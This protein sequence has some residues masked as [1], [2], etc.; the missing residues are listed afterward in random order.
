MNSQEFSALVARNEIPSVLFFEGREEHLKQ[1]ALKSLRQKLLPPGMED[2]N[3]A[4]LAAPETDEI[5]AAAETLPFLA[6]RRLIV[7]RDYPAIV[8]R[9]E[10]EDR[11]LSY[12]PSVPP[13]A[14]LLFYCVQPVKQ[15]KIKNVVQKLGGLV[16]FEPLKDRELTS[17]VTGAFHDLGRECDARTADALIFTVGTDM[18]Q[19][20]NEIAK[21]AAFHPEDPKVH[22]DDIAALASPSAEVKVFS[23]V[24][25]LIA[26]KDG[27]AFALLQDLLRNGESRTGILFMV[28]RQFRLMQHIKIMQYEKLTSA[29]IY[30]ALG[31]SPWSGQQYVKQAASYTGRQVKEAVALCLNTDY[32]VK[33]GLLREEGALESVMLRLLQLRKPKDT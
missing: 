10:A 32:E 6:D 24:D 7:I 28:L 11:L 18:N 20:L 29:Q 2:L 22:P 3:E 19:L 14:V 4:R 5:I 27:K 31:M 21:I 12:L 17:F 30:E 15:K 13:T 9:S 8:G 25:A 33:A 16:K 1:E 26:G 23:L